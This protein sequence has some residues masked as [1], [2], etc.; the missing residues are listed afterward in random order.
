ML[1]YVIKLL[2]IRHKEHASSF[3]NFPSEPSISSRNAHAVFWCI[4]IFWWWTHE[5]VFTETWLSATS[6]VDLAERRVL[7]T[8]Y[9]HFERMHRPIVQSLSASQKLFSAFPQYLFS[10]IFSSSMAFFLLLKNTLFGKNTLQFPQI[11]CENC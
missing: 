6:E 9:S 1:R 8:Y 10:E 2:C 7:N 11:K 5:E 3:T 4:S